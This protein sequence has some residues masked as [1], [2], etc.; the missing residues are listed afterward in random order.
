MLGLVTL[1]WVSYSLLGLIA[2]CLGW[3]LYVEVN[4][5]RVS[6]SMLGL[7]MLGLDTLY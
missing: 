4:F 7:V 1:C 2:L 3:L 5:V 6:N